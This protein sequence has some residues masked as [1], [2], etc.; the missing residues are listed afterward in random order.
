[1]ARTVFKLVTGW[2][3]T[4]I[5]MAASQITSLPMHCFIPGTNFGPTSA[6]V[7]T[8]R[9]P[10]CDSGMPLFNQ[11]I[12]PRRCALKLSP[13]FWCR[14]NRPCKLPVIAEVYRHKPLNTN[15]VQRPKI[16]E[17]NL[18]VFESPFEHFSLRSKGSRGVTASGFLLGKFLDVLNAPDA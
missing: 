5:C 6:I 10:A 9:H 17:R 8:F 14:K 11:G 3:A 2:L 1:M 12:P 15:Q 4:I 18:L 16:C 7:K 13:N